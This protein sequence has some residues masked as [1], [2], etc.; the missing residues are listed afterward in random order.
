[1]ATTEATLGYRL[2]DGH[3]LDR[4]LVVF[5]IH[6]HHHHHRYHHCHRSRR[7][8]YRHHSMVRTIQKSRYHWRSW[9]IITTVKACGGLFILMQDAHKISMKPYPSSAAFTSRSGGHSRSSRSSCTANA[10]LK[11]KS[12]FPPAPLARPAATAA[13]ASAPPR[14]RSGV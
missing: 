6:H 5:F 3:G 14:F 8:L 12:A 2:F 13:A 10:F 11:S 9:S 1:M 7:R 4:F